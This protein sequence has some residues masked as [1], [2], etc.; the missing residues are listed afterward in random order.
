MVVGS[1]KQKKGIMPPILTILLILAIFGMSGIVRLHIRHEKVDMPMDS[2]NIGYQEA[3]LYISES[4]LMSMLSN[5]KEEIIDLQKEEGT[6]T[7]YTG[8][9]RKYLNGSGLQ[10]SAGTYEQIKQR[11][12][13]LIDV[14][15]IE[16]ESDFTKMSLDGRAV[17][18]N[19][20]GEIYKLC[21]LQ[22]NTNIEGGIE[23][24]K[25]REGNVIYQI[26]YPESDY[27]F[28][29][30]IFVIT[31]SILFVLFWLIFFIIKKNNLFHKEVSYDE[32]DEKRF[33]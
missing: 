21:G 32:F 20:A 12:V 30:Y 17:A 29:T 24:I 9:L 4:L 27:N 10:I 15:N 31:L 25:D 11:I 5:G 22:L 7:V 33:A 18:I 14:M 19:I 26:D 6:F 13:E 23:Q 16:H 1:K 3:K 8:C 28:Q 2:S